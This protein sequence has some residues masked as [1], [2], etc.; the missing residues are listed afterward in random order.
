MTVHTFLFAECEWDAY[1]TYWTGDGAA[2]QVEGHASITHEAEQWLNDG[3]MRLKLDTPIEF[4]NRYEVEPF[5]EGSDWT[6]WVSWN[7]DLGVLRGTFVVVGDSIMSAY[8]SE[9]GVYSGCETMQQLEAGTYHA[10]GFALAGGRKLSSWSVVL[11]AT[12]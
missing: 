6:S 12:P 9:D 4:R 10:W 3:F 8:T 7:P 5:E 1:G 11:K 2:V